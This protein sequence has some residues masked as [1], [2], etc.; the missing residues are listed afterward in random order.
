MIAYDHV[1]AS[2]AICNHMVIS[3][4]IKDIHSYFSFCQQ[5]SELHGLR[6]EGSLQLA[7]FFYL[8]NSVGRILQKA[9]PYRLVVLFEKIMTKREGTF[10]V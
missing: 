2:H 9:L 4:K 8:V 1:R 3:L 5:L 6:N 7:S 10:Q